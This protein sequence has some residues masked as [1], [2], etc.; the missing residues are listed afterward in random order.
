MD[1]QAPKEGIDDE[2]W[3]NIEDLL[4]VKR[5]LRAPEKMQHD[6]DKWFGIWELLFPN[7]PPPSNPCRLWSF[8][9]TFATAY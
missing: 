6:I 8:N 9:S 4:K 5:G 1:S 7:V 3:A 2:Q